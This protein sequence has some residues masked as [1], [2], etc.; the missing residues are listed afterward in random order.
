FHFDLGKGVVTSI[1]SSDRQTYGFNGSGAGTSKL[2][3]DRVLPAGEVST[4]AKDVATL[5]AAHDGVEEKTDAIEKGAIE[6]GAIEK[7]AKISVAEIRSAVTAK[8]PAIVTP[9]VKAQFDELMGSIDERV[10]EATDDKAAIAAVVDQPAFDF[11]AK[12]L[13]GKTY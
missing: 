2:D 12:D 3:G 13:S 9:D 7:G 5:I 4:L 8:A 6:K 11:T 10:K 1:S